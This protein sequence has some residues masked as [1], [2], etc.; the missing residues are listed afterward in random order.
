MMLAWN[1]VMALPKACAPSYPSNKGLTTDWP[2]K[3]VS[4]QEEGRIPALLA[5]PRTIAQH[6]SMDRASPW[7]RQPQGRAPKTWRRSYCDDEDE[8]GGGSR[9]WRGGG[10]GGGDGRARRGD[11][12]RARAAAEA[13]QVT[14]EAP[15]EEEQE[16]EG[17]FNTLMVVSFS[18]TQFG[19]AV[20]EQLSGS[21]SRAC[22]RRGLH[23][24]GTLPA[25]WRCL[26]ATPRLSCCASPD[27]RYA[28]VHLACSP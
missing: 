26:C 28:H 5:P 10:G 8:G 6:P 9:R 23:A 17:S 3:G 24:G 18:G 27:C 7:Q 13:D 2:E 4:R 16:A 15:D 12:L 14:L 11:D 19:A 21:V 1:S 20:W 22:P 25:I